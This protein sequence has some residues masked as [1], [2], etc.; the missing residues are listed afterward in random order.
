MPSQVHKA[1]QFTGFTRRGYIIMVPVHYSA[2]IMSAMASQIT[3]VSIVYSTL[4][5][6]ADQRKHQSSASLAFVRGILR[7]PVNFLHKGPVTRKMFPCYDVIMQYWSKLSGV[8]GSTQCP[9]IGVIAMQLW[10]IYL[11]SPSVDI[12]DLAL[13]LI[14][15]CYIPFL[16]HK[17]WL[18]SGDFE[19]DFH[20]WTKMY[21][22]R[23]S[24]ARFGDERQGR[25][26]HYSWNTELW[27][28]CWFIL[29]RI[30]LARF[31]RIVY[32][33]IVWQVSFYD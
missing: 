2:V 10:C 3:G 12:H 25:F 7:W 1:T 16:K 28:N 11:W 33:W 20:F 22:W 4:C 26:I 31:V 29:K 24:G 27:F 9:D 6:G 13:N 17:I 5:S 21:F 15:I 19:F 8:L 30:Y 32:C 23:L 14:W 18:F